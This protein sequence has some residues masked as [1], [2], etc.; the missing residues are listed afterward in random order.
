MK[1]KN[2]IPISL[3]FL[4]SML[5]AQRS[6]RTLEM[7]IRS[8]DNYPKELIKTD[9]HGNRYYY[10]AKQQARIYEIDGEVIVVMD[11]L[12]LKAKP[13][14][15]NHLD[16]NFYVFLN[17]K[18][19]RVYPL[20]IKALEQYSTLNEKISRLEGAEKRK[21][22]RQMQEELANQYEAQLRDLTTTEGQI[23]AKLM[24][25]ATGKTVYEIIKEMRGGWSAFWWNIKGN[26]ADVDIKSVYDPY[27]NREDM[28]V[29]SLLQSHWNYGLY[30]PYPGHKDFK[31]TK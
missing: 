9:E 22:S 27:R 2:I 11:E 20:F 8:L 3:F 21:Y 25:R 24:H 30:E 4:C 10:D 17:K 14:F 23:F 26:A 16:R 28:F 15:N 31:V 7:G 6:D 12:Y 1:F 5:S 19:N 13:K 18:L 29:E